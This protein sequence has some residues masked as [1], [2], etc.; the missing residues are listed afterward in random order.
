[1]TKAAQARARHGLKRIRRWCHTALPASRHPTNAALLKAG[2]TNATVLSR[3]GQ[4]TPNRLWANFWF[5]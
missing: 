1:M 5:G 4:L 2:K 3:N